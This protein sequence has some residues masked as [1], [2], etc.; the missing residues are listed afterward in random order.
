MG[1]VLVYSE[2]QENMGLSSLHILYGNSGHQNRVKF[3]KV[4]S[5]NGF[6]L[7]GI[8]YLL[9]LVHVAS[10]STYNIPELLG[11]PWQ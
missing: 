2:T 11:N 10:L 9:V 3:T 5:F 8:S 6:E 7:C 4:F 1:R